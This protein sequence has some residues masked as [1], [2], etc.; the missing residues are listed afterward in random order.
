MWRQH[1]QI[2]SEFIIAASFKPI[3]IEVYISAH[4]DHKLFDHLQFSEQASLPLTN[5][6]I[7]C[8][9]DNIFVLG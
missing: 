6:L 2:F 1:S 9:D 3:K 4:A 7:Y 5:S 8:E